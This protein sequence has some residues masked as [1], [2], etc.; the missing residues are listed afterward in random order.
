M[1]DELMSLSYLDMVVREILRLRTPIT[2]TIRAANKC[3]VIPLETP[4]MGGCTIPSSVALAEYLRCYRSHSRPLFTTFVVGC[5]R[6][7]QWESLPKASDDIPGAWGHLLSF[8][9]GPRACI[10]FR[11]A[12]VEMK[13]LIFTPLRAFEF[14]PALYIPAGSSAITAVTLRARTPKS[15][16]RY[17][18]LRTSQPQLRSYFA[19]SSAFR[20]PVP[21]PYSVTSVPRTPFALRTS[22]LPDPMTFMS[23]ITL[24][25]ESDTRPRPPTQLPA[26]SSTNLRS[27]PISS[28]PTL[29]PSSPYPDSDPSPYSESA[30][31]G[32]LSR[33]PPTSGRTPT[34]NPALVRPPELNSGQHGPNS[35]THC[36]NV[37]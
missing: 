36:H 2:S 10:G 12:L 23:Q 27:L 26:L 3:D 34:P 18:V 33:N 22:H 13:A 37:V 17:S 35:I 4:Y 9:G 29:P 28:P 25:S 1:M 7:E 21:S 15:E 5:H 19:F 6:P 11:F 8:G 20:T 30:N 16:L 32:P 14:T 24:M 31:R